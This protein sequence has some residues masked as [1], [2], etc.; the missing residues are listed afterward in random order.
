MIAYCLSSLRRRFE[1]TSAQPTATITANNRGGGAVGYAGVW[2]GNYE[3]ALISKARYHT[4]RSVSS[5]RQTHSDDDT[6]SALNSL[7]SERAR[8]GLILAFRTICLP[9]T[10]THSWLIFLLHRTRSRSRDL[11]SRVIGT[12]FWQ[13]WDVSAKRDFRDECAHFAWTIEQQEKKR[14]AYC[15]IHLFKKID[16]CYNILKRLNQIWI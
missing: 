15:N 14:N 1:L 7:D 10:R 6:P 13:R 16:N 2:V 3:R 11:L 12:A 8:H 5:A 9:T 4:K